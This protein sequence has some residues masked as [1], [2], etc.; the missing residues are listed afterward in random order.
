[1][2]LFA[3]ILAALLLIFLV[4][5]GVYHLGQGIWRKIGLMLYIGSCGGLALVMI[6]MIVLNLR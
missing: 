1:M 6:L 3:Y 2:V 4:S 5:T